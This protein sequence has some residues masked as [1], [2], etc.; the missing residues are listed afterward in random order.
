MCLLVCLSCKVIAVTWE[1][2]TAAEIE[3][4]LSWRLRPVC[5]LVMYGRCA[6]SDPACHKNI[7]LWYWWKEPFV[8]VCHT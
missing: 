2:A 6:G 7:A 1:G 3:P 4:Y 5:P 8:N